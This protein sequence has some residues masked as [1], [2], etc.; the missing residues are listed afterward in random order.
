MHTEEHDERHEEAQKEASHR[1][2]RLEQPHDAVCQAQAAVR[3]DGRQHQKVKR[4]HDHER[5]RGHHHE[6]EQIGDHA[7]D[8]VIHHGKSQ[9]AEDHREYRVGV[10]EHRDSDA[11][12]G[13]RRGTATNVG[14]INE[15]AT[16]SARN[17]LTLNLR[18]DDTASKNGRK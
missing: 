9:H 15:P 12:D 7:I 6:L 16:H 3:T 11:E 13:I 14:Y 2:E 10:L 8:S 4:N 1:A 17:S 5:K 18:A